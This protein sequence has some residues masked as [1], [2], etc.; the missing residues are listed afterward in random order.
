MCVC[1]CVFSHP[2]DKRAGLDM[3]AVYTWVLKHGPRRQ[4]LD[5][6]MKLQISKRLESFSKKIRAVDN[7]K[8]KAEIT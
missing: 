6:R 5:Q 2:Y 3:W 4:K 8:K 7:G 1:A